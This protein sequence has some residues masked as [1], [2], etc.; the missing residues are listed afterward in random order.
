MAC[1][2]LWCKRHKVVLLSNIDLH[3]EGDRKLVNGSIGV[4]QRFADAGGEEVAAAVQ[5]KLQVKNP[6]RQPPSKIWDFLA[7]VGLPH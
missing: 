4:V 2:V 7:F 6:P 5:S 3:A 1:V